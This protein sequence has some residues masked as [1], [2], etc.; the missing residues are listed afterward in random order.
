MGETKRNEHQIPSNNPSE[1]PDE[2]LDIVSGGIS[3][4]SPEF[5]DEYMALAEDYFVEEKIDMWDF[6]GQRK[7][8]MRAYKEV[9]EKYFGEWPYSNP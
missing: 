9:W 2:L 6:D 5:I 8:E 7:Q 4:N 1:L 3:P